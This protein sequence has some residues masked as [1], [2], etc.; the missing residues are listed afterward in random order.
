MEYFIEKIDKINNNATAVL[1]SNRKFVF[2]D[3]QL[4][5]KDTSC[6]LTLLK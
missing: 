4:N 5:C 1:K 6:S 2:M 3:L